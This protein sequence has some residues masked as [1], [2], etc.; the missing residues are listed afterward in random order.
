[1]AQSPIPIGGNFTRLDNVLGH[2]P[3][4]DV[5]VL[6]SSAQHLE[7]L[8]GGDALAFDEDAFGLANGLP[9]SERAD[10]LVDSVDPGIEG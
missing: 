4:F 7:R 3:Q 8:I 1:M 6:G 9:G 5:E 10:Q 2:F